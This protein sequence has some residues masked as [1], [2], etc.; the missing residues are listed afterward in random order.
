MHQVTWPLLWMSR[1][2]RPHFVPNP[3]LESPH[4]AHLSPKKGGDRWLAL[5]RRL[6]H[7]HSACLILLI[8]LEQLFI[9]SLDSLT[10]LS[11][12]SLMLSFLVS[13]G[14]RRQ[15]GWMGIQYLYG[16]LSLGEHQ[17]SD[18]IHWLDCLKWSRCWEIEVVKHQ[19][20]NKWLRSRLKQTPAQ[21]YQSKNYSFAGN[22]N[23]ENYMSS[24]D[25]LNRNIRNGRGCCS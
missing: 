16:C 5:L 20:F 9:F 14:L 4:P 15:G 1:G 18:Y 2:F 19:T 22:G 3:L 17:K 8:G 24:E 10:L 25:S 23:N 7:L 21:Y 11:P 6:A 13:L 12:N